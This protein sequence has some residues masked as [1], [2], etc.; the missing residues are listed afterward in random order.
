MTPLQR[1]E[2]AVHLQDAHLAV[3]VVHRLL[4]LLHKENQV[5][6]LRGVS[7]RA[8]VGHEGAEVAAHQHA[9]GLALDVSLVGRQLVAGHLAHQQVAH[10]RTGGVG[11]AFGQER[12]HRGVHAH[13]AGTVPHAVERRDVAESHNPFRRCLQLVQRQLVNQLNRAIAAT[14]AD[15]G[16]DRGVAECPADVADALGHG[17][18]IAPVHHLAYVR[19]DD[20]LQSPSAQHVGR[21]LH[22]LHRREVRG[23]NQ[24]H[25]VAR[26]QIVGLHAADVH[27]IVVHWRYDRIIFFVARGQR[28]QATQ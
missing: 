15:D 20:R 25:L 8:N 2:H 22:V 27:S 3:Y 13:H 4:H 28:C 1:L 14:V 9:A 21:L 10:Q 23:R 12:A 7:L 17:S 5:L 26:L 6:A 18:G 19:A 24:R 11:A 16:L